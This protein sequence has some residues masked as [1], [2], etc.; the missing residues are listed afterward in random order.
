[1]LWIRAPAST[2]EAQ[3]RSVAGG[4]PRGPGPPDR[5]RRGHR[6]RGMKRMTS[7]GLTAQEILPADG[8]RGAL[9]GRVWRPYGSGPSV[10]AIRAD[11]TGEA[12]AIDVTAT[13]PTV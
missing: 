9:V 12:R 2:P 13:F 10:V 7:S 1:M 11:A 6:S 4:C 3:L 5:A 8:C